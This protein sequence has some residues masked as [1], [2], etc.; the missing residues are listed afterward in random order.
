MK[1]VSD[2]QKNQLY[3]IVDVIILMAVAAIAWFVLHG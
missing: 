1:E 2:K 3:N